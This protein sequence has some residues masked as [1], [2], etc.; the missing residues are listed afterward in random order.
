MNT[1]KITVAPLDIVW[2]DVDEN[3]YSTG[4]ILSKIGKDSDIVVLPELFSTGFISTTDLL[5]K[6]AEDSSNPRV[7]S[8]LKEW[9]RQYNFAIAGSMLVREEEKI[10]NRG[11]FVE[12]SGDVSF[13]DKKHLF[14]L[15]SEYKDF[16]AGKNKIAIV[17]FR[18]WNIALAICYDLRFPVWLRNQDNLYD[19]LIMPANWPAKR[20]YAWKHLLIARA[21]EN[22]AFVIGANR[23]GKDD[24]GE[25]DNMSYIFNYLGKSICEP[26]PT[27]EN[28]ITA[29]LDREKLNSYRTK[30]PVS[31]DADK[32][33]IIK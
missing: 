27:A 28:C 12:P 15:S 32:F 29:S 1:L 25:Y 10:F 22:Q 4:R 11:F 5:Y 18:G 14:G 16:S 19:V 7:I 8:Q 24:S 31:D 33:Q 9:A 20:G 6:F 30:F 2:T 13:Y 21:I 26:H 17:R 23:S 3:L